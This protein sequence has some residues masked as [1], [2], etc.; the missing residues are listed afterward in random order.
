[1]N[2]SDSDRSTAV[3][4]WI[5]AA[6]VLVVTAEAAF[7]VWVVDERGLFEYIGLDYRGSRAAGEAILEHGLA[8]PYDLSLLEDSER[9]LFDHY[10]VE[11]RRHGL[12][13]GIVPAPYPPPF[14]LAFIPSTV[15]EPVP[16]FLAW[17]LVHALVLAL[18]QLRL[19][20]AFGVSWPGWL[21][22]AVLLSFPSFINFV[23]GQISIWLVVFFGEAAIAFDRGRTFRAGM[24]LGLMVFKPQTLV[25]IVPALALARQWRVL[26]G[27]AALVAALIGPTLLV[28][29]GWVGGYLE[30]LLNSAGSTG[31][32]MNTFPSSMTNWRAFYLNAVR[33]HHPL[34]VAGAATAAMLATGIAGLAC[35][36]G[37]RGDRRAARVAWLGVAAATCAFSWHAHVHQ[38]LMLVPPLYAVI[39]LWPRLKDAATLALLATSGTFL[40]AAFALGF[41]VAHDI[42]GLILL[43]VFVA[44][45]AF[46]GLAL[47]AE[48]L[49][50]DTLPAG[51]VDH[52]PA[53][54]R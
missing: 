38:S 27:M 2:T 25:V 29:G 42:L 37:L 40:L 14:T 21:I 13:F 45:V 46:C 11:S 7:L 35:S 44:V 52:E 19:A 54:H 23:M 36:R 24:W 49:T 26:G 33:F 30:G 41:G 22:V 5:V 32:V 9:R 16:G 50:E 39:A 6:A 31:L 34:L 47:R 10:V 15:L 8:A 20:R 53:Q 3:K 4:R 1:M 51:R 48:P 43:A 12:P 28:A 18:Y 17:T